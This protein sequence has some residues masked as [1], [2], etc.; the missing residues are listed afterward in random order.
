MVRVEVPRSAIVAM[1]IPVNEDLAPEQVEAD[2][3]LGADGMARAV[4][5]LNNF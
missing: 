4:R 1:G 3:V 5:V 2:V